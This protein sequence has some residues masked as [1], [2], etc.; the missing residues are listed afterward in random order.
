MWAI[1]E[2]RTRYTWAVV[3]CQHN[4]LA[5]SFLRLSGVAQENTSSENEH[6]S[7]NISVRCLYSVTG[8]RPAVLNLLCSE[9]V[10]CVTRWHS[11]SMMGFAAWSQ[12]L[13]INQTRI[14]PSGAVF[15]SPEPP[16][17]FLYKSLMQ[18]GFAAITR[19]VIMSVA[20]LR[21]RKIIFASCW[22]IGR[23]LTEPCYRNSDCP[24]H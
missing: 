20:L 6:L 16:N 15:Y 10:P 22:Q 8:T 12:V 11:G 3:W 18:K 13:I 14:K 9:H 4:G 19:G 2:S 1:F 5:D 21:Q 23:H 17:C 7:L 24:L